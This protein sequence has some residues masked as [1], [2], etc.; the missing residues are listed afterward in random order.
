MLRGCL[1]FALFFSPGFVMYVVYTIIVC[2][3]DDSPSLTLK[4]RVL[5]ELHEYFQSSENL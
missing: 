5:S 1:E 2:F 3:K 4:C